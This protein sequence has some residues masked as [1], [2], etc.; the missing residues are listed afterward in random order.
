MQAI[1]FSSNL[2][3]CNIIKFQ[4]SV[5]S[6]IQQALRDVQLDANRKRDLAMA[7]HVHFK[8]WLYGNS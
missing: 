1:V 8:D 3:T 6:D 4:H 5:L 7:L 2:F